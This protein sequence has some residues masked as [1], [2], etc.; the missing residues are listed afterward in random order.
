[1][2]A[3]TNRILASGGHISEAEL[4]VYNLGGLGDE[5][6]TLAQ[7]LTKKSTLLRFQEVKS[8]LYHFETKLQNKSTSLA[9][10]LGKS[11]TNIAR[12]HTV[13]NSR[14][15]SP[16]MNHVMHHV[17]NHDNVV[18]PSNFSYRVSYVGF[19]PN[20]GN[21]GFNTTIG[22]P[23][24]NNLDS[25]LVLIMMEEVVEEVEVNLIGRSQYRGYF[26]F[27]KPQ[28]H[29][30]S[31]FGHTANFP[32]AYMGNQGPIGNQGINAGNYGSQQWSQPSNGSYQWNN[33]GGSILLSLL[34]ILL[35]LMVLVIEVLSNGLPYANFGFTYFSASIQPNFATNPSFGI[36]QG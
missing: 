22:N 29:I 13:V 9:F 31:N 30:C 7:T 14:L 24:F 2:K 23:S 18:V 27:S 34:T 32:S 6:D 33:S 28:C 4:G 16:D 20:V 10:D 15:V 35:V 21:T 19:N 26:N 1:M 5:Y 36:S 8:H 17:I 12:N 25:T 3:I 11:S